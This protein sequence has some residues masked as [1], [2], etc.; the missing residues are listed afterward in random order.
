MPANLKSLRQN[1]HQS[2]HTLFAD[3]TP[4]KQIRQILELNATTLHPDVYAEINK[5]LARY[6]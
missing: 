5:V 6:E 4:V 1:V 2:F 3:N